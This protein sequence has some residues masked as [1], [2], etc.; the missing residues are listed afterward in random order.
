VRCFAGTL[1][2][3]AKACPRNG[4]FYIGIWRFPKD[5][6]CPWINFAGGRVAAMIEIN[7]GDFSSCE[8]KTD[9]VSFLLSNSLNCGRVR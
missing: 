1:T 4:D 2:D 5:G 8:N 7:G 3:N 9:A 6:L